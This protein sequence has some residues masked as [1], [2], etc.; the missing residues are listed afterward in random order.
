MA[1]IGHGT[2]TD[3][4]MDL[5]IFKLNVAICVDIDKKLAGQCNDGLQIF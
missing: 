4:L 2:S 5:M 1:D 3:Q